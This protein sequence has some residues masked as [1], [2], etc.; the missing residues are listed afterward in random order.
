MSV[1]MSDGKRALPTR[2]PLPQYSSVSR[3]CEEAGNEGIPVGKEVPFMRVYFG[4]GHDGDSVV[5][6]PSVNRDNLYPETSRDGSQVV[7]FED[8]KTGE[9]MPTKIR[10]SGG[11]EQ[12]TGD[13]HEDE[14]GEESILLL[15]TPL[16]YKG[17]NTDGDEEE[18]DNV[19]SLEQGGHS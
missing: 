8:V 4:G 9:M 15:P 19:E 2:L 14:E 12:D 16:G 3:E 17:V 7:W 1:E 5:T 13:M 10:Y 18:V 11:E 6:L